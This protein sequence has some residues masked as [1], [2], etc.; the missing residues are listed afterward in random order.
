MDLCPIDK[1]LKLFNNKKEEA[2]QYII[3]SRLV[4]RERKAL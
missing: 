2:P 3:V 4:F 1:I